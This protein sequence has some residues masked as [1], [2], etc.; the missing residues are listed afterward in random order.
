MFDTAAVDQDRRLIH[1]LQAGFPLVRRPYE[2]LGRQLCLGSPEVIA[3]IDRLKESGMVRQIGPVIDGRRLGYRS[4]LLA[5]QIAPH[6]LTA[7]ER[8]ITEHGGIS[9]AYERE[10]IFNVWVTL[11]ALPGVAIETAVVQLA[12]ATGATAT[13]SLPAL[14]IFKL[15][16]YFGPDDDDPVIDGHEGET[17]STMVALSPTD[18][19]VV[20]ELQ[21]DLPLCPAPFDAMAKRLGIEVDDF[22]SR[23]E[24]LRLNGV[25]RRY[26][27]AVNHRRAGYAAN[28]MA[29]WRIAPQKVAAAGAEL[30][31]Q[32]CV[33]HCYERQ[34]S[35]LW[36]YN[37][38]AMIHGAARE[39]CTAVT[40]A[41]AIANELNDSVVL[42]ST[43]EIK[44]TR[45]RYE[46]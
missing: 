25:I 2:E 27:A 28:A 29:C 10:H 3:H 21:Q 17:P 6:Q 37:L 14:K 15:R 22:L 4:T 20:N 9:H 16:A 13:A 33:S 12:S 24:F 39:D 18:R 32:A 19:L 1:L 11:V 34:T 38:F 30:A 31:A 40:R 36:R 44:K 41:A 42:F 45:V 35:A 23:C 5:M 26:G 46:V 7:A 8:I 43:R